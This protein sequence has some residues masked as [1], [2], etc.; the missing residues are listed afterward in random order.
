[1]TSDT[2]HTR[3]SALASLAG[4]AAIVIIPSARA[5]AFPTQPVTIL[6]GFAPGGIV[7]QSTRRIGER[8]S[9]LWGQPV[10]IENK[11]GANGNLAAGL[12]ARSAPNGYT[13]F[14]TLYDS[15]VI[16]KAGNL[17]LTYDPMEDL[18][19]V[20]LIGDVESVFLVRSSSPYKT[21]PQFLAE[22]K[23]KGGK[24]SFGTIG[25][26]STFHLTME[27]LNEQTSAG[28]LHVP[29][30]GGTPMVTDLIG[31]SI[32]SAMASSLF[33]KPFVDSGKLRVLA[34]AGSRRS[35]VFP[36]VP[37]FSELGLRAQVP[38][39]LGIFAPAKT[40][41]NLVSKLNADFI[42]VLNEPAMK[43]RFI[44]EGVNVGTLSPSDF[45]QRIL[46]EVVA[47][48]QVVTRNRVNLIE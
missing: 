46:K 1:M 30:K 9:S 38:Y 16:A 17:K 33:S 35:S 47:I 21:M 18:I 3:R 41:A 13:L 29:Y 26:G 28:M 48:E 39:A 2:K 4:A 5:Q 6:V 36:D 7:D 8:L 44:Q 25:V 12:A 24:M 34:V 14:V 23:A 11:A 43:S 20:A 37:S 22:A 42:K 19:P 10:V 45:K 32:E 27:Q 15:L 31:E 40:P